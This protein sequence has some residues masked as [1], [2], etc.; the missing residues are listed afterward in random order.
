[1]ILSQYV[2]IESE[3]ALIDTTLNQI[4]QLKGEPWCS[5]LWTLQEAFLRPDTIILFRHH[6][7]RRGQLPNLGCAFD[8]IGHTLS[9]A[10]ISG[11]EDG[12]RMHGLETAV[13]K[14]GFI[15]ADH[16]TRLEYESD[17][18]DENGKNVYLRGPSENPFHL[19]ICSNV[20]TTSHP[21]DR[22]YA[23]VQVFGLRLG[24]PAPDV[25]G[26]VFKYP[27]LKAQLDDAL[28]K[29]YPITSQLVI[30]PRDCKHGDS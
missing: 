3:D 11:P 28:L 19:L 30:Q 14:L 10:Q 16:I 25:T 26:T 2:R 5:S 24:K 17:T 29:K 22:I 8:L 4:T 23:I 13:S 20:R 18:A 27:E 12:S 6:S 1:L 9:D 15:P 7:D 21:V